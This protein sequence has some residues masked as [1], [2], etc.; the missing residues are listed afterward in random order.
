MDVEFSVLNPSGYPRAGHATVRWSNPPAEFQKNPDRISLFSLDDAVARR[1]PL[2]VQLE[3]AGSSNRPESLLS[4]TLPAGAPI[5]PGESAR[6]LLAET[7]ASFR[8]ERYTHSPLAAPAPSVDLYNDRLFITQSLEPSHG[9]G[10]AGCFGGAAQSVRLRDLEF[11]EQFALSLAGHD[12]EKRCMQIDVL[13]IWHPQSTSPVEHPV[14]SNRWELVSTCAGP[15]RTTCT[16]ALRLPSGPDAAGIRFTRALSLFM[17]EDYILDE[18]SIAGGA[19][20]GLAFS[21]RYF[22]NMDMGLWPD[23]FRAQPTWLSIGFSSVRRPGYGFAAQVPVQSFCNPHPGYPGW[24]SSA[25][26]TFSWEI[27]RCSQLK[28]L[29]V[30]MHGGDVRDRT[31]RLWH[32]QIEA[33]LSATF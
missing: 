12:P 2:P 33:P 21:P 17:D 32:E 15:V 9:P 27:Q 8:V 14:F 5:Q 28:C 6:L 20:D 16:I 19:S 22:A 3:P 30:F 18:S 11:L 29:H 25:I 24:V 26:R 10:S 13:R 4:F 7:D 31:G 1:H 23:V